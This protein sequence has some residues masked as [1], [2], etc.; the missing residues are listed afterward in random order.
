[1]LGWNLV[2]TCFNWTWSS[3]KNLLKPKCIRLPIYLDTTMNQ[4]IEKIYATILYFEKSE[5]EV[6]VYKNH[7]EKRRDCMYAVCPSIRVKQ[8]N[9]KHIIFQKWN[10]SFQTNVMQKKMVR[11]LNPSKDVLHWFTYCISARKMCLFQ[12]LVCLCVDSFWRST[13]PLLKNKCHGGK[14]D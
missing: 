9:K 7:L 1:M 11:L 3:L 14:W 8:Q 4:L 13:V 2:N 6:Y 12:E 10:H 5:I